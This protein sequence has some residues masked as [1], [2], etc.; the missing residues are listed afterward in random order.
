MNAVRLGPSRSP[1]RLPSLSAGRRLL[2]GLALALFA[3]RAL[4]PVGFEPARDGS[5]AL[6]IC[7]HGLP[8]ALHHPGVHH[9]GGGGDGRDHCLFCSSPGGAPA[10]AAL[11]L[12]VV[13]L[14]VWL[15]T[16]TRAPALG[17]HRQLHLP[18][19]RAPPQFP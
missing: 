11:A 12:T 6:V 13:L 10:A 15:A 17:W 7:P 1:R 5:F 3:L 9:A 4:V 18:E 16:E 8:P 2:A 14:V 19:A